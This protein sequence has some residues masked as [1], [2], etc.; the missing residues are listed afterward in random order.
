MKAYSAFYVIN[1]VLQSIFTLLF[2]IGVCT[3]IA[4]LAV[5]QFG[6]PEWLYIPLVLF[7][8]FTGLFT[9]IRF[10]IASMQALERLENQKE[11]EG[12]ET[13]EV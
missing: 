5:S 11:G 1:I 10:I 8:V 9:M 13:P 2:Q 7:G 3:L 12:G 4:W 6:A